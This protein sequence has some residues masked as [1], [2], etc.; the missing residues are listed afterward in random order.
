MTFTYNGVEYIATNE[1]IYR[2]ISILVDSLENAC[3]LVTT[4]KSM[5]DYNFMG[6]DYSNMVVEKR[7]IIVDS[8]IVVNIKL[9]KKSEKELMRE[10]IETLRTAMK[11]LAQTTNKTTTS[12]INRILETTTKGVIE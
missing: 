11:E 3:T 10:E 5:S 2:D 9:R 12:K 4:F 8:S 6:T 7:S 1:S